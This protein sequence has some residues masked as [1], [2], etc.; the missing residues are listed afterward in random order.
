MTT[1]ALYQ[2]YLKHPAIST[3]SRK[4]TK[5]GIFFALKGPHFNGNAFARQALEKGAAYAVID[6]ENYKL[7]ERFILV[8]DVL[9]ALQQLGTHHR[10]QSQATVI[11]LTGSNGKTTTKEL[12]Y[13]VLSQKYRTIATSGNLN[14][15]IGVPLSLLRIREDTEIAVIEM[16]AN[17][18]KEI[19]FLSELA[20][21]DHGYITNFGKAHLEGFGG[22]EGVIKGKS[23]LYTNLMARKAHVF[24][25]ADDPIQVQKLAGYPNKTGFSQKTASDQQISFLG[26]SPLVRLKVEG[27]EIHT[28]LPGKYNSPNAAIAVLMGIYFQVPLDLIKK[29]IE[30]Y[31][32]ENN[33]SQILEKNGLRIYLDAYNA[34][35]TSMKAA[36]E[37]F[38]QTPGE[39]KTVILGDMFELGESAA[40]EH[41]AIADIARGMPL[42]NRYFVGD[43][44]FRATVKGEK[45]K[46]FEDFSTYLKQHPLIKGAVLIK[47]S[48]GMALERTLELL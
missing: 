39:H 19:E 32:P 37:A 46:S 42:E 47:G 36:L 40:E 30:T 16:G 24:W 38:D 29:G 25:N 4:I 34:N 43:H 18:Q 28:N 7:D 14:N 48:R 15:H 3:D 45:F 6:E 35:P 17:H 23:E 1:E 31:I 27:T 21:P 2:I 13:A 12:I 22:V 26:A 10:L 8:D 44:F 9:G 5:D 33:R 20:L 41:Q 11:S